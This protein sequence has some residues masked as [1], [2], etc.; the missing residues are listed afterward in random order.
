MRRPIVC[1]RDQL[2]PVLGFGIIRR[3][4][5]FNADGLFHTPQGAFLFACCKLDDRQL[6][7]ASKVWRATQPRPLQG[8]T[9]PPRLARTGEPKHLLVMVRKGLEL[10]AGR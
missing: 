2:C 4:Y 9:H 1:P 8:R 3:G 10:S 7:N 6:F 5:A